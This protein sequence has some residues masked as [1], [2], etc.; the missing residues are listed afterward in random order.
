MEAI[1]DGLGKRLIVVARVVVAG[2][3][4]LGVRASA[5]DGG[6]HMGGSP[7]LLHGHP[8]VTMTG[9]VIKMTVDDAKVTV[10]CR[11]VFT[12]NGPACTVR[13]G[14]PDQGVGAD[15]PDEEVEI[16]NWHPKKADDIQLTYG[17][18][19]IKL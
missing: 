18:Q 12:N 1:H 17:Y 6:I 13:M 19:P 2:L 9:E 7:G 3:L 10:D 5:N 8:T 16:S 4:A 11:F 15:D 14:F